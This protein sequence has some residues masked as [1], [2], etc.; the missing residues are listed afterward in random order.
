MN[1]YMNEW[2][3]ECMNKPVEDPPVSLLFGLQGPDPGFQNATKNMRK[4]TLLFLD[5]LF[6]EQ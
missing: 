1:E 5:T 3:N 2:I 6:A 4:I